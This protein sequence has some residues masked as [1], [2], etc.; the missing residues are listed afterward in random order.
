MP[1][2]DSIA[3]VHRSYIDPTLLYTDCTLIQP[4]HPSSK[5][6]GR[7]VDG[8]TGHEVFDF[9]N[10]SRGYHQIRMALEDEEK[11]TF[12]TE[13]GYTVGRCNMKIYMDDMLVKSKT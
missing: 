2:I 3:V 9:M 11:T 4:S 6:K 1:G 13:Y 8:S 5:R 10:S 7:L 12:I